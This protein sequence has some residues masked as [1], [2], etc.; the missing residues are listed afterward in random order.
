MNSIDRLWDALLSRD[1]ALIQKTYKHL[2]E[3]DQ[4]VI[5][6]HLIKMTIDFGWHSEQ[7]RSAEI[8]IDAI[9]GMENK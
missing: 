1:F 7:K 2:N 9:N 8:A 5:M 4:K 6:D 3:K